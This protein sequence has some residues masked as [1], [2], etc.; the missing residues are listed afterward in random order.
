MPIGTYRPRCE[1]EGNAVLTGASR[2]S[3]C[4]QKHEFAGP[5]LS[6]HE[7]MARYQ[8]TSGLKPI[9]PHRKLAD[10][11]PSE[12]RGRCRD[13]GGQG[14]VEADNGQG[15]TTCPSCDGAGAL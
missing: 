14:V 6:M 1:H 8:L 10:K 11:L 4:G 7:A 2:C 5:H 12:K 15:W 13:C 3:V 9:G